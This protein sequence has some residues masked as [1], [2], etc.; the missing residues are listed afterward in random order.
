[1]IKSINGTV[2]R[3]RGISLSHF[4]SDKLRLY[5]E[6]SGEIN[7]ADVDF[8]NSS[9]KD[10]FLESYYQPFVYLTENRT[11]TT[12]KTGVVRVRGREINFVNL[13]EVDLDVGLDSQVQE[14][15]TS[16]Y[17][18]KNALMS[19]VYLYSQ[20]TNEFAVRVQDHSGNNDTTFIGWDG[21]FI[22]LG[23]SWI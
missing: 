23:S 11:A 9:G 10:Q 4:S 7:S 16:E 14:V 2:P 21:V 19:I 17:Q 5:L 20:N 8:E 18:A 6:G 12:R 13:E 15:L 1:M 22:R 3:I